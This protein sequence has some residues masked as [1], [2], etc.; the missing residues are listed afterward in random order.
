M[1]YM[2]T[3]GQVILANSAIGREDPFLNRRLNKR[4]KWFH[5]SRL[6]SS[7]S[8]GAVEPAAVRR[9]TCAAYGIVTYDNSTTGTLTTTLDSLTLAATASNLPP[10]VRAWIKVSGVW[11]PAV[12]YINV[13]GTWKLATSYVKVN[14]IWI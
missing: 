14:G 10:T 2:K 9:D 4:G 3:S 13:G 5:F 7:I 8:R 1:S 6:L 12:V 11:R